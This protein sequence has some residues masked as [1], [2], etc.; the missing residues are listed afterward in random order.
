MWSLSSIPT[1]AAWSV[2][3]REDYDL[4][5]V[6]DPEDVKSAAKYFGTLSPEKQQIIQQVDEA[7]RQLPDKL[8]LQ[9]MASAH[10]LIDEHRGNLGNVLERVPEEMPESSEP[11]TFK[12]TKFVPLVIGVVFALDAIN[13]SQGAKASLVGN[14]ATDIGNGISGATGG[15][16]KMFGETDY[17]DVFERDNTAEYTNPFTGEP[18]GEVIDD[19]SIWEKVS[20]GAVSGAL[21]FINPFTALGGVGRVAGRASGKVGTKANIAVGRGQQK[22]GSKVRNTA[23]LANRSE[24]DK[25]VGGKGPLP[26]RMADSYGKFL[27][28]RGASRIA[29]ANKSQAGKL[30]DYQKFADKTG[31]TGVYGKTNRM[32]GAGSP[33]STTALRGAQGTLRSPGIRDAAATIIGSTLMPTGGSPD[34]HGTASANPSA[35][36]VGVGMA[37][38][39]NRKAMGH[40]NKKIWQGHEDSAQYNVAKGD[41]M[42]IGE[43]ILKEVDIRIHKAHCGTTHKADCPTCGKGDCKCKD[44]TKK[45]SK[46]PAHGMVIIIGSKDA[47]PG[48]SKDGKRVKK[49]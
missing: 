14:V 6:M 9:L 17:G 19:P 1:E 32:T 30:K 46:K 23:G 28:G 15:D 20:R 45:G 40:A 13:T 48:P 21:S 41:N 49:N 11:G 2:L 36:G 24:A 10:R 42:K 29:R 26:R 18:M 7:I 5:R 12:L 22:L 27:E 43:Q 31:G 25:L 34:I 33:V 3:K 4:T 44:S 35:G 8:R 39:G 47:G 38:V 16:P 37:G